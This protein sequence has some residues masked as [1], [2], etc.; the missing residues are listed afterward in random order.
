MLNEET[1]MRLKIKINR[2]FFY[3]FI[4]VFIS[5]LFSFLYSTTSFSSAQEIAAC[6]LPEAAPISCVHCRRVCVCD[7]KGFCLWMWVKK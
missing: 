1:L 4:I 2:S 6:G 3:T 7:K 5:I